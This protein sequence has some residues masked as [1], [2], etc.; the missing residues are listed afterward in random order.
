MPVKRENLRKNSG[1]VPGL[2]LEEE[3]LKSRE[4]LIQGRGRGKCL[5]TKARK[6]KGQQE[7][8]QNRV[9]RIPTRGNAKGQET[10][11][12][13]GVQTRSLRTGKVAAWIS[14]L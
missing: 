6:S 13:G 1:G 11:E 9:M 2:G 3:K 5:A 4:T 8:S 10:L 7:E 12:M 14:R